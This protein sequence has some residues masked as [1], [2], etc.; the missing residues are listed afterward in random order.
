MDWSHAATAASYDRRMRTLPRLPLLK[1][2]APLL[3]GLWLSACTTLPQSDARASTVLLVSIDGLRADIV[4]SGR[5]PTLDALA[6]KGVHAAWMNPSYPT[7]TFPN[8][9]TLVTGLRPDHHGIVNNR[10]HDAVLGD[11]VHKQAPARDGRW[12]G[13][14]PIW[15][16][17]QRQGGIAATMFWPGSEAAIAGQRPRYFRRFDGAMPPAARVDQVLAWLDLPAQS[18]PRLVTLYLEQVDVAAHKSGTF[19]VR[20]LAAMAEVD[21]ALARLL[22]GLDGRGVRTSTN[23]IVLSDHGMQDAPREQVSYLDERLAAGNYDVVWWPQL[24]GL[25]PAPGRAGA[26]EAAFLGRHD[27]YACWRKT[28]TPAQWHYGAHP[29]IPPIV[30]QAD[31]GW[32]LQ[33]RA[34][35]AQEQAVKGE[36]GYAPEEVSMRAAFVADGPG[37]ADGMRIGAFDNVDVYPLLARLLRVAPA[38]NDGD[39]RRFETVLEPVP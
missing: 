39:G 23:V 38:P 18:R 34:Q 28:E 5:M 20:A 25:M 30:C 6:R 11:F 27:H 31:A 19:S 13:G 2:L 3:L 8:H 15:A 16:T 24:V 33:S 26:V 14:E 37:F 1:L 9:Y 17:L 21:A 29:R 12:Y 7:L 22:H 36:H 35:P 4:G 10:M 32:R